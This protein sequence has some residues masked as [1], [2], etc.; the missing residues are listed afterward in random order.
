MRKETF[1]RAEVAGIVSER[2][3]RDRENRST[4][5]LLRERLELTR[6]VR[7]LKAT[8]ELLRK[9]N[10]YLKYKAWLQG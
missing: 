1:T 5:A 8:N 2:L 9:E 4:T 6:K 7:E 3:K 10:D